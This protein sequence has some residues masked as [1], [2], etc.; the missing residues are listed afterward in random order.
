M[1]AYD[2]MDFGRYGIMESED[3]FYPVVLAQLKEDLNS[4]E[5]FDTGWGHFRHSFESIRIYTYRNAVF[6]EVSDCMDEL[7]DLIYDCENGD[8]LEDEE[9]DYVM[10][11][12]DE[13]IEADTEFYAY[14]RLPRDTSLKE[15]LITATEL[16][17]ECHDKLEWSF[18]CVQEYVDDALANRR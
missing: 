8:L 1:N 3:T 15:I 10:T 7:F 17:S 6:V 14:E 16:A 12:W 4:G 11:L 2:N 18:N 5:D 9:I 13:N